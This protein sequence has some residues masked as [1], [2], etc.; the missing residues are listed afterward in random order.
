V[1][2]VWPQL[3]DANRQVGTG[4]WFLPRDGG[5]VGLNSSVLRV[6]FVV[7]GHRHTVAFTRPANFCLIFFTLG[8]TANMQYGW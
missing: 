6:S 1:F 7:N 2:S 5:G 4:R 3:C 8:A